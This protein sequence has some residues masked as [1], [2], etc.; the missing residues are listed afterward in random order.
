MFEN[1][2]KEILESDIINA[3]SV[4]VCLMN[5][6]PLRAEN[7]IDSLGIFVGNKNISG[8]SK[9]NMTPSPHPPRD[10]LSQQ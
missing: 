2:M 6:T 8:Y 10:R 5:G 7:M 4:Q 9:S 3:V 1:Y